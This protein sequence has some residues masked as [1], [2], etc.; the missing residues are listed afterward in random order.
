MGFRLLKLHREFGMRSASWGGVVCAR[1][2]KNN[3]LEE[4]RAAQVSSED[5]IAFFTCITFPFLAVIYFMNS[6][7]FLLLLL[8]QKGKLLQVTIDQPT[9]PQN[10]PDPLSSRL[11]VTPRYSL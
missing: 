8:I 3:H 1:V 4:H 6:L 2:F 11:P 5:L 7:C 10:D 9:S